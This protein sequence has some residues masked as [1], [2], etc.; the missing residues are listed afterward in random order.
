MCYVCANSNLTGSVFSSAA[1]ADL[2]EYA[3]MKDEG[4]ER[5]SP[6]SKSSNDGSSPSPLIISRQVS[7]DMPP[8]IPLVHQI[9][10]GVSADV[11]LLGASINS[12]SDTS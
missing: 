5:K 12:S 10:G 11:P 7:S 6:E 9:S 3:P 4:K 2:H 8:A 1:R